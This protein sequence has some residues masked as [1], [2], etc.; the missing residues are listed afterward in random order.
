MTREE[1]KQP[2]RHIWM[3]L[4]KKENIRKMMFKT[5]WR[6]RNF[7]A[8]YWVYSTNYNYGRI[9]LEYLLGDKPGNINRNL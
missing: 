1:L 5:W 8:A 9:V 4:Y 7:N 3:K 6:T 2:M